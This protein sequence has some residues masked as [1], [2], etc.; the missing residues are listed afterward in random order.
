MDRFSNSGPPLT[1]EAK[2]QGVTS[3]EMASQNQRPKTCLGR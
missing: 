3:P 1:S 2:D